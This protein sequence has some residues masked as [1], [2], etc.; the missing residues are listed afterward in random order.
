MYRFRVEPG[1]VVCSHQGTVS[2]V[3]TRCV[4]CTDGK[5]CGPLPEAAKPL[6]VRLQALAVSVL[7][8]EDSAS[9][10]ED[11]FSSLAEEA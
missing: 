6:C 10:L 1:K 5:H 3:A 9:D 4:N 8:E 11:E 2:L 7:D